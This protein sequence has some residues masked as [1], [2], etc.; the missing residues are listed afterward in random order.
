MLDEVWIHHG[1]PVHQ[2]RRDF[3]RRLISRANRGKRS[4]HTD[5]PSLY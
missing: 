2:I 5:L 1:Q 3:H 4:A